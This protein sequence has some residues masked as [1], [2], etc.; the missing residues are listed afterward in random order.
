MVGLNAQTPVNRT[1]HLSN[2]I[3]AQYA[4]GRISLPQNGG[5][6]TRFKHVQGVPS[7]QSGAG[8]SISKLRMIDL[9]VERLVRLKGESAAPTPE[10][11]ASDI[12]DQDALI[13]QYASR[14]TD[15]L[16]SASSISPSMTAGIA[17]S[18]MVIDL[19]A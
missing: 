7:G 9:L 11:A 19:V 14:L 18:G 8:Y 15:A 3:R 1:V 13:Q 16:R 4:Q 12:T 2:I 6:Y 5:L 17:E 10:V